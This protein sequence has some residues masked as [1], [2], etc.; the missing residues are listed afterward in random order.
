MLLPL[1][2]N[3]FKHGMSQQLE[4]KW[5]SMDLHIERN[6][7]FFKLGNSKDPEARKNDLHRGSKGIGLEN[8]KRRLD[9]L[10][11]GTNKFQISDSGDMFLVSIEL[12][13]AET[14]EMENRNKNV[15]ISHSM[16]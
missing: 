15:Q 16:T 6:T 13:L 2:E 12:K 5:I 11:P 3:S 1:I 9:L 7:L 14:W 8:V 4:N 10:Y